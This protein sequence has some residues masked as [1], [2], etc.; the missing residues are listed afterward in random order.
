MFHRHKIFK[1]C[2]KI[3]LITFCLFMS[4]PCAVLAQ[5]QDL[6][7]AAVLTSPQPETPIPIVIRPAPHQPING[8]GRDGAEIIVM[9]QVGDVLDFDRPTATWSHIRLVDKPNTEGWIQG[10]YIS[11]ID[12]D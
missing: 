1:I 7:K 8:Y 2:L 6:E 12:S 9:E 3:S 11:L 10:D 5:E 4:L